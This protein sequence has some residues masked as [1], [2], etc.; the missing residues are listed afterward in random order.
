[1]TGRRMKKLDKAK[2]T[3]LSGKSLFFVFRAAISHSFSCEQRTNSAQ[4][5][6]YNEIRCF[7]RFQ[8]TAYLREF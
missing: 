4:N 7:P 6:G 3:L 1:M 2:G 8:K 5:A